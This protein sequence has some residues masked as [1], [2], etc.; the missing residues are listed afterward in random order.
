[1]EMLY[2]SL[3]PTLEDVKNTDGSKLMHL[4]SGQPSH[5]IDGML[6]TVPHEQQRSSHYMWFTTTPDKIVNDTGKKAYKPSMD[7]ESGEEY[8]ARLSL[9]SYPLE[10]ETVEKEIDSA[11]NRIRKMLGKEPNSEEI[12]EVTSSGL[13][14]ILES[15]DS[16]TERIVSEVNLK[17]LELYEDP[18]IS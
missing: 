1:M 3:A 7:T 12:T 15:P 5:D 13:E 17:N 6:T 9:S 4:K 11:M 2:D 16:K 8:E 14:A 10:E 18:R